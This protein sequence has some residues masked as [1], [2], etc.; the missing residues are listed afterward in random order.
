M[1]KSTIY[2]LLIFLLP[3]TAGF[4]AQ[5]NL[6][7]LQTVAEA[8]DFKSTSTSAQVAEFVQQCAKSAD[9]VSQFEFGKTVE[10]R[11]MVG[12]A[13][14]GLPYQLGDRDD[15]LVALVIG[16]I[17]SGECAGKEALLMM[18]RELA[19]QPSH[20]WLKNMVLLIVPNY[21]SDANDR[22]GKN[23]RP[24]Q[25]G[26]EDGMGRRE[27][28]Q[29]LDLNRDFVK[30]ESPEARC[31]VGLI[32][33]C[34][35]D[36]FI[37]CHT[38]NG[39]KHQYSLT[40]DIP[41]NPAT[42]EPIRNFLRQ[43]MMPVVTERMAQAGTLT[44]YYGNFNREHTTWQTF[45]HQPRYSTEYVGL[46]G[47]L[48]ILSEAYSY[49]SYKDRIQA[50]KDFVSSCFDFA[51][52]NASSIKQMIRQV[53]KDLIRVAQ[54][55][56]SRIG[57]S[58][59]AKPV[60][61]DKKFVLKGY[62]DDQPHDYECD[63]IG[64]YEPTRSVPLPLAYL[65]P[66]HMTRIVDRMLMHGIKVESVVQAAERVVSVDVIKELNRNERVFQK[67]RMMQAQCQRK[68]ERRIVPQGTFV[69]RTAQ[70][71]GRL[72]AYMLEAES[73]DGFLF[74]N[75]LDDK[76]AVD[77]EY[78]I[79]RIDQ[80]LDLPTAPVENVP[81]SGRLSL[82]MIGGSG[83]LLDRAV[84]PR[85]LGD[86][87][88]QVDMGGRKF[89]M[90]ARTMSFAK[91]LDPVLQREKLLSVL[92]EFGIEEEV[93]DEVANVDPLES[94][95]RKYL[96]FDTGQID[97]VYDVA[98]QNLTAVGDVNNNAEL[99]TFSP[100][101]KKLAFVDTR[102]LN[103]LDL[104]SME[105][106]SFR[107]EDSDTEL[108]GKLDWV[109]QEELYGRGNFKGFW[110][111]PD[112]QKIAFLKL[113]ESQVRKF[114]ITDHIPVR[115]EDE[116]L[117]YP[118][119]GD[120][121]PVVSVGMA[122]VSSDSEVTW[123]NLSDYA[124]DEPLISNVS[125]RPDSSQ[126]ILQI[127]NREQTY[128][129]VAAVDSMDSEAEVL[130]RDNTSAWIES[131]GEPRWLRDGSFL[132][133]S[134]RDGYKHLYHYRPDGSLKKQLTRGNWEVRRIE[135]FDQANELVYFSAAKESPITMDCYKVEIGTGKMVR[136]TKGGGTHSVNFNESASLFIDS[137]STSTQPA[138]N[139]LVDSNGELLRVLN[140]SSDDRINYVGLARPEFMEIQTRQGQPLDAMIIRPP[141]F[142][143]QKKYPVLIH[144]YAG[145][146]AP[147]VRDRFGGSFDL[148]HQTL[149]QAGYVIWKCDNQ[150]AS[151]RSAKNAWP[152]HRNLGENELADIELG[153][154]WLK[155][156]SWV[157]GDR[158]GLW[159]WS[160]GGYITA[161]ALTHSDSFK[162]GISGA[163]VTDW[164]NYDTIY[165]ERLMGTPQNN[166]DGYDASSVV[167]AA[168]DLQGKLLLIHGSID[169]NVHLS[170][171]MQFVLELQQAQKSFDLMIY[172]KN[173]HSVR[174][175]EQA[176]HLRQLMFDFV[177][178]NL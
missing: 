28:A 36:L 135:A 2:S 43:K 97:L 62:K 95:D 87:Q 108:L 72:V 15:R 167:K 76:L 174:R 142:D 152:I 114:T 144:A 46:R 131:P 116:Y 172:P 165:T 143:P 33:K 4:C 109:Y 23:N 104:T 164:R 68:T 123:V 37:D 170:N 168:K 56:P 45:G 117:A 98:K 81:N 18:I 94:N 69:V 55:Q 83:S 60:A 22:M 128:L 82:E 177:I 90:N 27:N 105:T 113:D 53:D 121:N 178:E 93:A 138:E 13:V 118:K 57:V 157:D 52:E 44:F 9:H 159:G 154:S 133:L 175:S 54:D 38:T 61:F 59:N 40:Y 29:N 149:A 32:D 14:S 48:A 75:F 41:H 77:E 150:S 96:V 100:D 153:V 78:P 58:L 7:E 137:F 119:A 91:A 30:L 107:P 151:Y 141:N 85:W 49:I 169:D 51:H 115:G 3:F 126:L 86:D 35:P 31:L 132:W 92:G 145:P 102:G 10:G 106:I 110:F 84:S 130:F 65:I 66:K 25:I 42:A 162:I 16:N 67:H 5:Q 6:A 146:Q 70:P 19:Q 122:N 103:V 112:S 101:Q 139:R 140:A 124:S 160:Y 166:P 24:G 173:R 63:F 120:P 34:D 136:L 156:Q 50:T 129:D 73:D 111:S 79:Q 88:L 171:T 8:S 17:H 89:L 47:R 163:P 161:Y 134:P 155:N 176:A 80:V 11:A 147:Q 64:D 71:L 12:V 99:F 74:W 39:S 125:W 1:F 127:Q 158:I 26:P 21:N 148:W 20:K